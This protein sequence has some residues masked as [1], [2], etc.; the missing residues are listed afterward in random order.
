M[1][2]SFLTYLKSIPYPVWIIA[3]THGCVDLTAGAFYV[4]LPFIKMNFNLSYSEV[5]AIVLVQSLTS[6][7]VQPLFGYFS[8]KYPR[9]WFMALVCR[10]TSLTLPFFCFAPNYPMI[11][12]F[13]VTYGLGSASFHSMGAITTYLVAGTEKGLSLRSFSV[14]G[15]AG[16]VRGS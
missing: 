8:Y 6:S 7:I 12:P 14:A 11:C 10:I 2:S 1:N 13:N 4:A 9:P 3:L 16:V 5:T 15:S